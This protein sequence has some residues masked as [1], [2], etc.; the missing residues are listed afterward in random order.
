VVLAKG[1]PGFSGPISK[2]WSTKRRLLAAKRNKEKIDMFDFEDPKTRFTWVLERKSKVIREEDRKTTAYHEGGH[3]LVARFLPETDAVNKITIIPGDVR[4][5]SPGFC[6]KSGISS[7]RI[8]W[9]TSCPSPLAVEWPKRSF[10]N[11]S[12]RVLPTT[13][14]RPRI[15]AR[16][17]GPKLG[18]E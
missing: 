15:L 3:A 11:A 14:S 6:L 12:A 16:T 18:N 1:T 13:S 7:T 17:D 9:K 4:P 5:V 8:S 10:L 2:T